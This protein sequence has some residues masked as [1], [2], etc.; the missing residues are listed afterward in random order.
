MAIR[1]SDLR[2]D[3]LN[4]SLT[5]LQSIKVSTSDMFSP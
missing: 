1:K 2:F 3:F 4:N 5:N